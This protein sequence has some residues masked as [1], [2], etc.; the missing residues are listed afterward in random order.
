M[1]RLKLEP[2][3]SLDLLRLQGERVDAALSHAAA[4][5]STI[6]A[7]LGDGRAIRVKVQ[8]TARQDAGFVVS[9]RLIDAT[10]A[11]RA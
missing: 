2:N 11:L 9:G 8:R 5:G 7:R 10:R 6:T 3:G 1:L 4:V